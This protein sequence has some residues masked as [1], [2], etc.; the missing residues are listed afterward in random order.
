M[1]LAH[2]GYNGQEWCAMLHPVQRV[3][4][5]CHT[6]VPPRIVNI[7][8]RGQLTQLHGTCLGFE[9]LAV[10]VSGDP[11]ILTKFDSY[12]NAS[13]LVLTEDGQSGSAFFGS[14]P[15]DLFQAVQEKPLA[16]ENHGKGGPSTSLMQHSVPYLSVSVAWPD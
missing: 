12:D 9:A 14:L 1:H 2:S 5:P 11:K 4:C 16:M 8:L 15:R 3:C 13:P 10:I 7:V 6:A